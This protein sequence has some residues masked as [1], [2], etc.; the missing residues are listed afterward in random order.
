MV[1]MP[2]MRFSLSTTGM[3]VKSYFWKA[4]AASSWSVMVPMLMMFSFIMS[5]ITVSG[6]DMTR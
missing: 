5:P 2:T 6:S 3:A 4:M 1:M